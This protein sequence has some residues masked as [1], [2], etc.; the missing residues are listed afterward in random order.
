MPEKNLSS[1]AFFRP[2]IDSFMPVIH[3]GAKPLRYGRWKNI[4]VFYSD[5]KNIS[6]K[7]HK[8]GAWFVINAGS[9]KGCSEDFIRRDSSI[10]RI[11][12]SLR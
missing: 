3:A 6:E 8:A 7:I 2:G 10:I 12:E 9:A 5:D 4:I 11:N 1:V